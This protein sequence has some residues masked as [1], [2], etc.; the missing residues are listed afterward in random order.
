M[1]AIASVPNR[2]VSAIRRSFRQFLALPLATV[3]GFVGL[4]A[5]VYLADGSWS[6]D[7]APHGF[8]WLGAL[9]GDRAALGSLLATVASSIVTVTSITFSLLLLAVQQGAGALTAQVTD[10]FMARRT[11]QLYFGYFVGLSVFVLTTLVTNTDYHRPVFA[12]ALSLLLTALALCLIIVMIYNTIDQMRPEQIIQFIHDKV[13][14]ARGTDLDVLAATRRTTR[15][16]WADRALVRSRE[17]GYVVGL[18]LARVETALERHGDVE[19]EVLIALGTYRAVGDPVFRL[20]CGPGAVLDAEA[21][22]RIAEETLAAFAYDDGRDLQ[23]STAYGLHQLATI[24][25][26]S[27]STSK[28]NP[29]PGLTVIQALRD[30]IAQWSRGEIEIRGDDGARIVYGDAA[31]VIAT[32]ALEAVIVVASESIQSQTLTEAVATLAILLRHV[33]APTAGRLADVAHRALSSLG[34]HVLTRQLEA[35]LHDLASALEERG[36]G[37]VAE[38][39]ARASAALAGSLGKLNSRST[40][41]PG[42]T[43]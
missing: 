12:A 9:M 40:R 29:N 24:A 25:W 27:V 14:E 13:L 42:T 4:S 15:R 6:G 36:F 5:L 32:D 10:Q 1:K 7:R 18:D 2:V 37:S 33:E 35:A 20:R 26:T 34:E 22:E 23:T 17:S 39:V 41:V 30:I 16:D 31:P 21:Q 28:S 8:A 3:I 11:N 19:V 38:E 43:S